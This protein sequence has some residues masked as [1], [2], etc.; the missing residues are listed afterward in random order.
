MDDW[1][2]IPGRGNDGIFLPT[3]KSTSALG[4]TQLPIKWVLV[5][6]PLE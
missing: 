3:T 4:P 6:L 5:V 1:G 2:S